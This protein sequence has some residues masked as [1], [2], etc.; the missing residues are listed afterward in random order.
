MLEKS[1]SYAILVEYRDRSTTKNLST[2]QEE[3]NQTTQKTRNKHY[4]NDNIPKSVSTIL[5][6][7][8]KE[9]LE[10]EKTAMEGSM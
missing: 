3:N 7:I 9:N 10:I 1:K 8:K 4:R 2:T 5:Q 6:R